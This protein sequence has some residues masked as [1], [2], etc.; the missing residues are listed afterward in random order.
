MK[1]QNGKEEYPLPKFGVHVPNYPAK[2][3]SKVGAN[4]DYAPPTV[5][6]PTILSTKSGRLVK[7]DK[8][9]KVGSKVRGMLSSVK[10]VVSDL[11]R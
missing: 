5:S 4:V 7:T 2:T 9:T 1:R 6:A 11:V 3:I 8:E 10:A